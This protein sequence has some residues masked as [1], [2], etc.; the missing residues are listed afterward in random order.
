MIIFS[1]PI[2]RQMFPLIEV[3]QLEKKPFYYQ[4]NNWEGLRNA[5]LV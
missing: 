3:Y 5:E 4:E 1:Q 2:F